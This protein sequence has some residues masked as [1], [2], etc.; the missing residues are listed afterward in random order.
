M[1]EDTGVPSPHQIRRVKQWAVA[2]QGAAGVVA[3]MRFSAEDPSLHC[4]DAPGLLNP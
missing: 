1:L 2:D 3:S 4:G